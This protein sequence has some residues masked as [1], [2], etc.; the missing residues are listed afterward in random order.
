MDRA[1]LPHAHIALHTM[2]EL[3]V[4]SIHPATTSVDID[5]TL[6]HRPTAAAA[7]STY[8]HGEAQTPLVRF[9]VDIFYKKIHNK[10]TSNRTS[11]SLSFSV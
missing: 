2:T 8:V 10:S 7:F 4:K 1:M 3:D 6:Q 9:V 5:S 11:K